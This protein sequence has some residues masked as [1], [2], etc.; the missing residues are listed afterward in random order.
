[1]TFVSNY[2]IDKMGCFVSVI[3]GGSLLIGGLWMRLLVNHNF[4][5]LIGGCIVSAI[6]Q[7][8]LYNL[9]P[10]ISAKWFPTNQV[11]HNI[12]IYIYMN[13]ENISDNNRGIIKSNWIFIRDVMANNVHRIRI[14]Q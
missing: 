12:Y 13:L 4:W 1:M 8:L 5:Y 10:K 2:V 7:P 9:P 3:C 14:S 6:G 11:D